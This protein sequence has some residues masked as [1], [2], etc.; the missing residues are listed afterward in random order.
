[1]RNGKHFRPGPIDYADGIWR[2]LSGTPNVPALYQA[3]AG[4]RIVREAGLKAIRQKSLL[5]TQAIIDMDMAPRFLLTPEMKKAWLSGLDESEFNPNL[6]QSEQWQRLINHPQLFIYQTG[7]TV[8]NGTGND[9]L[10][11]SSS[12]DAT[13][14][15]NLTGGSLIINDNGSAGYVQ[16][17]GSGS[18]GTW[19]HC[20]ISDGG[21]L[22]TVHNGS[23]GY[24]RLAS[25]TISKGYLTL[26]TGGVM[27]TGLITESCTGAS[28]G[29]CVFI[30]HGGKWIVE[31]DNWASNILKADPGDGGGS[32]VEGR[33][34]RASRHRKGGT[35]P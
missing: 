20:N 16:V 31:T 24:I 30:F 33:R 18:S 35:W 4:Y 6:V 3:R 9:Y 27:E 22:K 32:C 19:G 21:L 5:M 14:A 34:G 13:G 28:G 7:G 17:G 10:K 12:G 2:F 1:M 15:Y 29:E 26:G 25:H 11:V 23:T 8:T